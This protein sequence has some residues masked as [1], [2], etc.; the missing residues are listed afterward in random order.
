MGWTVETLNETVDA[1]VD[2]LPEDMRARLARI[3]HLIEEK[4]LEC[5]G[6]PHVKQYRGPSMGN[7]AERPQRDFAGT[8][9]DSGQPSRRHC[10]GFRQEDGQDAATRDRSGSD[11]REIGCMM[12]V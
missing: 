6:E 5:V 7:A 3:A 12:E 10:E 9:C 8:V 4:G 11:T 2:A 1:E